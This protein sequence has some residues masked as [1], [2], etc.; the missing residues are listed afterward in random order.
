MHSPQRETSLNTLAH[1]CYQHHCLGMNCVTEIARMTQLSAGEVERI[2][3]E[4]R[5]DIL[6]PNQMT[7]R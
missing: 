3:S 1:L 2:F 6:T 7:E 4:C 5:K